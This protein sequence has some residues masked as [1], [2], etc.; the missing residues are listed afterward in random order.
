MPFGL[1][2]FSLG[3]AV[4]VVV[5]A[6]NME[7]SKAGVIMGL[8]KSLSLV[9]VDIGEILSPSRTAAGC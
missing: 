1:P 3:G 6:V 9:S 2:H 8:S 5:A 4:A 7:S